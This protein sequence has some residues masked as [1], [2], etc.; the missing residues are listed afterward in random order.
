MDAQI[1]VR[2]ERAAAFVTQE[3][4][5]FGRVLGTLML[6]QLR[7][8]GKRG[9]AV[10]ARQLLQALL[11]HVALLVPQEL[12]TGW[13]RALA[14]Q[15]WEGGQRL[16]NVVELCTRYA[17]GK[18][19]VMVVMTMVNVK[20][21]RVDTL[22]MMSN[23]R[24]SE[25]GIKRH[26]ILNITTFSFIHKD[27]PPKEKVCYPLPTV[28][29]LL[30]Q[31]RKRETSSAP[32]SYSTVT[33]TA[34]GPASVPQCNPFP[35]M[36]NFSQ[37][38]QTLATGYSSQQM[39]DCHDGHT[40]QQ[41][42]ITECP[43]AASGTDMSSGLCWPSESKQE[44]HASQYIL[45][46]FK[47]QMDIMKLQEA[48][49]FLQNM[50]YCRTTWQDDDGDTILHIYTA[51]GLRE[52]AFAAAEKLCELGKLDSKEHKGKTALLVAVTANQPEIVQDLLSL[53]ADICTCDVNGQTALHLAATYGF[54]RIMQVSGLSHLVVCTQF[55]IPKHASN[56]MNLQ[57]ILSSG[58]RVDLEA[59]NF[60]GLTPLHCAVISHCGTTKAINSWL[61]DAS[62]HSQAEDKLMCLRFLIN[63]GASILSQE[64]KSNKTVLHLAVKEGNIHLVRFLLSP[65]LSDMQA[66]INL[67][68]HGH[69]ALHMAAGLHGSPCQEELIRLL[70]SCGADPS[71][72][73]LE[74][75]QPAHLLQS[76]DKGES[77]KLILKK[78]TASRRRFTSLQDQ[79]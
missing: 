62:L 52:Y 64:I 48:R 14:G 70:L 66:F 5:R 21:T 26:I 9:A 6:Q 37:T 15:A 50:D 2:V 67:K 39:Q 44:D 47:T 27:A 29:K 63:A 35:F 22:R 1:A 20:M 54:P 42:S 34:S 41:Y 79:E 24:Y 25:Y 17:R 8:P 68:A 28:K 59:R 69:T 3:A 65:P 77:L 61:A 4:A 73:N 31:K 46:D 45:Q 60:E 76:G 58:L 18:T 51:K 56:R 12:G 49:T 36:P 19:A 78:K 30:E 33:Y 11:L 38:G 74:N 32:P 43:V 55:R 71:I 72:R 13:E 40:T 7:R 16:G 23:K 57:V 75:D 10:H 53:G